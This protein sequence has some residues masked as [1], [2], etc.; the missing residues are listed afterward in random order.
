MSL[1][2][3]ME[4]IL[5]WPAYVDPKTAQLVYRPG[6]WNGADRVFQASLP[7]TIRARN[8]D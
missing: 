1:Y 6:L 3:S 5:Q 8:L 7:M 2:V 4:L